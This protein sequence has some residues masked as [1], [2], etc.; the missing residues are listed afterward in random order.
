MQSRRIWKTL[1]TLCVAAVLLAAAAVCA[2]AVPARPGTA[3]SGE[4]AACRSHTGELVT[5][6]KIPVRR[7]GKRAPSL[8]PVARDIPLLTIVVGFSNMPYDNGYDWHETVFSGEKSLAAYYSDM[9][10]GKFTFTPAAETSA[11]GVGGNTNTKDAEND[12]VVHVKLSTAHQ[13]W[14][15]NSSTDYSSWA[16]A[17]VKAIAAADAYVD[18]ASFDANEDRIITTNELAV[19]FVIAGYDASGGKSGQNYLWAHA[20]TIGEIISEHH[21]NLTVP[22]PDNT[23]VNAYIAI[24]EYLESNQQEPISVLAHELGHYLG[25]PDLYDTSYSTSAAWHLY[26]VR[27]C[28][29]MADGCWG[30][31]P[32]GGYIPY[33]MDVW[34]RYALGW[35]EPQTADQNGDYTVAAQSYTEDEAYSALFLPTQREGEYYLLENRRF[36]KWDAG[37]TE[38]YD[39]AGVIVWHIDDAVFEQ[40]NAT[41]QVNDTFHRPAVMPLYPEWDDAEDVFTFIGNSSDVYTEYP[42]FDQSAMEAMFGENVPLDLPLYGEGNNADNRASRTLSGLKLRFL[43]NSA[44]TMTVQLSTADHVH[45]IHAVEAV[46]PTCTEPGMQAHFACDYCGAVF[47]DAAGATPADPETLTIPAREHSFTDYVYNNNATCTAD[48]TETAECDHG[49]GARDTR[50]AAG[51]MLSHSFTTYTYNNNATCTADGTETAECDYGCGAHDTRAAAGTM[52][53]HSF[54]TYTDNNDATCTADGTETA[55]C[56]RGCGVTDTRTAEGTKLPHSFTNYVYHDDATCTADGTETASCDRGCGVTDTRT[57]EGT[58]LAHSFTNYVYNNDATCT[59]DGTET[60]SCDRGCGTRDTRTAEGTKLPH[61]YGE[62]VWLWADDHSGAVAVFTCAC[63]DTKNVTDASPVK[64]EVSAATATADQ[65]V[66]YTASVTFGGKT[67]TKTME[68]I[69]VPGT[70]T[71]APPQSDNLCPWD[72]TDHGSSFGGRLTRFFH[73]I[74]YFFAHLFG[75]K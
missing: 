6:D 52:L 4:S 2:A 22:K 38:D 60:A 67:Y 57:A 45:F 74:L 49:C 12:G 7:S 20:W 5:L 26:E 37:M 35:I 11:Y 40:Y 31:D 1:L 64:T 48:G 34:S 70:A 69:T 29:V 36:T 28:S 56:D 62:P 23:E 61:S 25:L 18:F 44:A 32:E 15:M 3:A 68:Q 43:D 39:C 65:V 8:D 75:R 54:T 17:L 9:S 19:A 73:G 27:D 16:N 42:C 21:V 24:P 30:I 10:F 63:G 59:A 33:S 71:G 14:L 41:N 55:S 51:T 47:E 13:K 53:S 66:T 46:D 72:D 58:K 50:T